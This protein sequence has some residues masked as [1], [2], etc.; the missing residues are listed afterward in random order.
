MWKFIYRGITLDWARQTP[1]DDAAY[2]HFAAGSP[3]GQPDETYRSYARL[4]LFMRGGAVNRPDPHGWRRFFPV[5]GRNPV[6]AGIGFRIFQQKPGTRDSRARRTV[7]MS[8]I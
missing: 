6:R 2:T 4:S 7:L 1:V 5:S 3:P 8:N